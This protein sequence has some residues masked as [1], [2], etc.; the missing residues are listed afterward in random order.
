M[1]T[2]TTRMHDDIA[3]CRENLSDL[4]DQH[5]RLERLFAEGGHYLPYVRTIFAFSLAVLSSVY[6]SQHNL[7][8][9]IIQVVLCTVWGVHSIDD[10]HDVRMNR[11]YLRECKRKLADARVQKRIAD[12]R[13]I[14]F[15]FGIIDTP[16]AEWSDDAK[17]V[18]RE[19]CITIKQPGWMDS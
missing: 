1:S 15:V 18:L 14:Q 7:P 6:M 16:Q 11:Q 8:I 5:N 4:Y 19:M 10:F 12:N 17:A 9:L 13:G 2:Y 3:Q